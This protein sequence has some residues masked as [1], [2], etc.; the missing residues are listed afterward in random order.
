M[1]LLLLWLPTTQRWHTSASAVCD[2][3]ARVAWSLVNGCVC[4]LGLTSGSGTKT[5]TC[6]LFAPGCIVESSDVGRAFSSHRD[7][8]CVC[9]R[10]PCIIHRSTKQGFPGGSVVKNRLKCWR[11]EFHPWLRKIPWTRAWP[12]APVFLPGESHGQRSLV[13]LQTMGLQWVRHG[14]ATNTQPPP[15][16]GKGG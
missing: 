7:V 1:F 14:W 5:M 11:P 6:C 12:P 13:G 10:Y 8:L 9:V 3:G 15:V 2:A 4:T 16:V